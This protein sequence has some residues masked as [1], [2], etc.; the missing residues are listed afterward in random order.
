MSVR[1]GCA[2]ACV[3]SRTNSRRGSGEEEER[4]KNTLLANSLIAGAKESGRSG[5]AE[6]QDVPSEYGMRSPRGVM[7]DFAKKDEGFDVGFIFRTTRIGT[8][9]RLCVSAS[10]RVVQMGVMAP[11]EIRPL[12]SL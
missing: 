5:S 9:N 1:R 8:S 12:S 7:R 10:E 6:V 2:K 3:K 11:E 4:V